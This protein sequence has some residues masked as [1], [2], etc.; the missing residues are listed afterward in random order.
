MASFLSPQLR[1][2]LIL[3][4]NSVRWPQHLHKRSLPRFIYAVTS[5]DLFIVF[6]LRIWTPRITGRTEP[7]VGRIGLAIGRA[8]SLCRSVMRWQPP[9][10]SPFINRDSPDGR[11]GRPH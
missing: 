8:T 3:A 1:F 4:N 9:L 6:L 7:R 11:P 10:T 2:A 5:L